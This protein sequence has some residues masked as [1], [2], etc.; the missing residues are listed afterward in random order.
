[1]KVSDLF[2]IQY[3]NSLELCSLTKEKNGINF[4]S[5]T[6]KNNGISAKVKRISNIEPFPAGLITVAVSG[7]VLETFLQ[8]SE[9]YTAFHIMVLKEKIELTLE[10]K[11]FYCL[12]IRSN[13]YKYSYGRQANST[14]KDIIIP[15]IANI[16][17]W[18]NNFSFKEYE[19][20]MLSMLFKPESVSIV[21]KN[22]KNL[23]PL[24]TLFDVFN[25]I[26]SSQVKR[27]HKKFDH[28]YIPYIRPSYKQET[29]IDAFLL[30]ESSISSYIYPSGTI[31]V[32]T[33]GQGSHT[34][35]YVSVYE[36]V[37]NSNV[38][39]LI[40]KREM[41]IPEK[42]FYAKCISEN[43]YKFSYGRKPKGDRLKSILLPECCPE[44]VSASI[45][46]KIIN[47]WEE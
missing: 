11:L 3:G 40:P 35:S 34:Y 1:M 42:L 4:I 13:N 8:N 29:S 47:E 9:F 37:P 46:D 18:I 17:S 15:D 24:N 36:F 27:Y 20:N 2:D 23:V 22:F 30:K 31:Y 38:S 19:K 7:N 44:Y 32:S 28:N 45:F 33:D 26:A 43:R 41:S 14:L 16:P 39:V 21:N 25:G 6:S 12:C 5:R 10:Q